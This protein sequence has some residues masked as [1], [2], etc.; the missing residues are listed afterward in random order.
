[1]IKRLTKMPYAHAC[2]IY[3]NKDNFSLYSYTTPVVT[4]KDGKLHVNGLYSM[5]TRRHIGAFM[6]EYCNSSYA[7]AKQLY[8]DGY[9]YDINTGEV[10]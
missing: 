2:V 9:D 6:Q 7:L 4:V 1:M 3:A 5:T 8:L 10:M